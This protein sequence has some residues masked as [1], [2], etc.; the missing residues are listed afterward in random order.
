MLGLFRSAPPD[1]RDNLFLTEKTRATPGKHA[2]VTVLF[3]VLTGK[4]PVRS[5]WGSKAEGWTMVGSRGKKIPDKLR[6][7]GSIIF[8]QFPILFRF[9]FTISFEQIAS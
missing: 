2:E 9:T 8:H 6:C 5:L 7:T 1:G 4:I 3:P